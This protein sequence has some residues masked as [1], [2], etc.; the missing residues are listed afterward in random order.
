MSDFTPTPT[1]RSD[2][3]RMTR[4]HFDYLALTT[5]NASE[6]FKSNGAHADYA[7]ALAGA[8]AACNPRFD[9]ER[10]ILACMPRYLVGARGSNAW[11][12]VADRAAARAARAA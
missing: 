11:E 1:T 10:F 7:A 8:L 9:A 4:Q 6:Y 3:P 5:R 12:R 2:G